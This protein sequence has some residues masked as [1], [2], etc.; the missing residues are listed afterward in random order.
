ML[1]LLKFGQVSFSLA[2]M[3]HRHVPF[4]PSASFTF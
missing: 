3:S 4:P 1:K 2:P